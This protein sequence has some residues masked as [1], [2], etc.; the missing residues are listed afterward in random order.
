MA[1]AGARKSIANDTVTPRSEFGTSAPHQAAAIT[2][3]CEC[4]DRAVVND[5]AERDVGRIPRQA[6]PHLI[7]VENI[8]DDAELGDER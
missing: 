8:G 6:Q 1:C 3:R 7:G 4:G 2:V 5:V